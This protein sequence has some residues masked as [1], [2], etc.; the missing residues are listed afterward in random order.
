MP[1]TAGTAAAPR[2][3]KDGGHHAALRQRIDVHGVSTIDRFAV[4]HQNLFHLL[5][6]SGQPLRQ[7]D[8]D[9]IR[10]QRREAF[11]HTGQHTDATPGT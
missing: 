9:V 10:T 1:T 8:F 7:R 2:C 5:R 6:V 11:V 4:G 3:E